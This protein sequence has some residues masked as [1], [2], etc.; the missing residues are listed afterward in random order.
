VDYGT[1]PNKMENQTVT[2]VILGIR[3]SEKDLVA[4]HGEILESTL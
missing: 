1:S 4:K 3:I 2:V